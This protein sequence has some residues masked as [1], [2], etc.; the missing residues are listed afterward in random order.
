[1]K[2]LPEMPKDLPEVLVYRLSWSKF[3]KSWITLATYPHR[4]V[5]FISS[6]GNTNASTVRPRIPHGCTAWRLL[7]DPPDLWRKLDSLPSSWM[8]FLQRERGTLHDPRT[9]YEPKLRQD[10]LHKRMLREARQREVEQS[11]LEG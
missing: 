1:M 4:P 5:K 9:T 10:E 6:S 3:Y 2:S 11:Q 8:P 7:T